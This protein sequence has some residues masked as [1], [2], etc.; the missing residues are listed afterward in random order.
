MRQTAQACHAKAEY[1]KSKLDFVTI[2]NDGPTFNEFVVQLPRSAESVAAA[3]LEKGFLAGVPLQSLG[4]GGPNDLLVAVTE[5]RTKA[6]LDAFAKAM[7]E[8]CHD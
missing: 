5:K 6:E 4:R 2:S 3:M 8:V 1:L 7:R